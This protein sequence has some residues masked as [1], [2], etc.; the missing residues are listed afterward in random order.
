MAR[1]VLMELA[2]A[3]FELEPPTR[4]RIRDETLSGTL[5]ALTSGQADL[6]LGVSPGP[7]T[8]AGL[9]SQ[10]MGSVACSMT[11][12]CAVTVPWPSPIQC[13][14]AVASRSAC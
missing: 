1:P 2:C 7:G 5:Q 11:T 6:A 12:I 9:H 13:S 3:F 8:A 14:A 4:L 10:P